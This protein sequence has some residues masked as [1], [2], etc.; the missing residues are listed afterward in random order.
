[1]A[2]AATTTTS[3]SRSLIGKRRASDT[4]FL[5]LSTGSAISIMVIL[6]GVAIFLIIQGLPAITANWSSNQ[7]LAAIHNPLGNG[8]SSCRASP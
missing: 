8:W 4:V 3:P 5:G 6:A 7:D 2:D 1:V